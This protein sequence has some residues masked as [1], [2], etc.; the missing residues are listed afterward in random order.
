MLNI[1]FASRGKEAMQAV[2]PM[3]FNFAIQL[4]HYLTVHTVS[5]S[6]SD[7][8]H[9]RRRFPCTATCTEEGR[10]KKRKILRTT[11]LH[12]RPDPIAMVTESEPSWMSNDA[13]FS[14][15]TL[16]SSAHAPCSEAQGTKKFSSTPDCS[17]WLTRVMSMRYFNMRII[18]VAW[19][20]LKD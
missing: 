5:C 15:S 19:S 18:N 3:P 12:S 9:S 16:R 10:L 6:H 13:N 7:T 8:M 11:R 14:S 2:T 1:S 4:G 20:F 17:S